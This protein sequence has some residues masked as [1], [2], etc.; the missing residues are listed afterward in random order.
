MSYVITISNEKGGVGKTTTALSLG[1]AFAHIGSSVLLVDLDA[2]ANLSFVLGFNSSGFD[3]PTSDIF[4]VNR[5]LSAFSYPTSVPNLNIIPAKNSLQ[6]INHLVPDNMKYSNL[7]S[8]VLH[9]D[10]WNQYEYILFDCPSSLGSITRDALEASNLLIIPTTAEYFSAF[11][12]RNMMS[13]ISQIR[14]EENPDLAYRIL[15]TMF[16]YNNQIH[17]DVARQLKKTFEQGLLNIIIE[18]DER[19]KEIPLHRLPI[20]CYKSDSS[21]AR[22]YMALAAE[23]TRYVNHTIKLST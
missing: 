16:E 21:G 2:H 22:Q 9:T 3:L 7:L 8:S 6:A 14:K 20:T 13:T 17:E 23:I 19:L 18:M 11:A 1:A 10:Q 15:I 4:V 5:K 12:L